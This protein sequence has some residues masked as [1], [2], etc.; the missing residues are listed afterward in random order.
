LEIENDVFVNLY[1]KGKKP[2]DD[3]KITGSLHLK[4]IKKKENA[5]TI[6]KYV[7]AT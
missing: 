4:V 7:L 2:S 5:W 3:A 1:G 6:M